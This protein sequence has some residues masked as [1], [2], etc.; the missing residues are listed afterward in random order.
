M[1]QQSTAHQPLSIEDIRK[2]KENILAQKANKDGSPDMRL[3]EN[4]SEGNAQKPTATNAEEHTNQDGTPDRRFEENG[5]LP[6]NEGKP[7]TIS[8]GGFHR[9]S[10]GAPDRRYIENRDVSD[11]EAKVEEA[12]F[13]LNHASRTM[14]AVK[15]Q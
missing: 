10:S 13:V 7:Q 12:K 3:K 8:T 5:T 9:T 6:P 11:E 1:A 4:R 14:P 2:A 15:K